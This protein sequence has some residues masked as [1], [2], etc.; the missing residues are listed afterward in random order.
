VSPFA[1]SFDSIFGSSIMDETPIVRLVFEYMRTAADPLGIIYGT[2]DALA[3]KFNLPLL[4]VESALRRLGEPDPKS[5]SSDEEG[6]RVV[7]E[8]GNRWR[9]VNYVKYTMR[10]TAEARREYWRE[11]KEKQRGAT[12]S[13]EGATRCPGRVQ[14]IPGMSSMSTDTNGNEKGNRKKKEA[15]GAVAPNSRSRRRI[16][17]R[18]DFEAWF[19]T[20]RKGTGRGTTKADAQDEY[21]RL[22]DEDREALDQLTADW[23]TRRHAAKAAGIFVP[24]APD[25]VRFLRHRRWEDTFGTPAMSGGQP[26]AN[27]ILA[28]ELAEHG[29]DPLWPEYQEAVAKGAV[30][31]GFQAFAASREV[32]S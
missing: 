23:L 20:Y 12:R 27:E 1:K 11:V 8:E 5:T 2:E 9:V 29:P 19:A 14:D 15:V 26:T 17:Y 7:R 28:G 13:P 6:R 4:D 10:E 24:E 22:T 3:R 31:V 18:E 16:S 21:L 30:P 25:P 32:Q